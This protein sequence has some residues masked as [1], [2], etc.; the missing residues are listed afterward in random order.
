MKPIYF[1]NY[2][3]SILNVT[4]SI[5][6][7]YGAK[8]WH[9]TLNILDEYL[10]NDYR[11]VVLLLIDGLGVDA[12]E[13]HLTKRSTIRKS[14]KASISSVFPSTTVA[15]TTS[16]LSGKSPLETGWFGWHQYFKEEDDNV[17]LFKNKSFYSPNKVYDHNVANTYI[18]YENIYSQ[19]NHAN[20]SVQ[21]HE[22]FPAFRDPENFTIDKLLKST[23][24]ILKTPGRHFIYAYWDKVDTLMHEFGPSSDEVHK[25][26]SEVNKAYKNFV[27]S[28]DDDTLV[29]AIAD[30]GQV[31]VEIIDLYKY[32]DILDTLVRMPSNESRATIFYVKPDK[33]EEFE[34]LFAN[35]FRHYF[36]LYTAQ[37]VLDMNLFG[38]GNA[39]PKSSEFL[40]DYVAI[41]IDNYIFN[42]IKEGFRMKGQHAGLLVEQMLVPLIITTKKSH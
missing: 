24:S 17:I 34:E 37:R 18:S 30:H 21:T 33:F 27:Q 23:H 5:L 8:N 16:V 9:P 10:E 13:K 36:N 38:L 29:I 6:K 42:S 28:I 4:N 11:N 1:P 15:A 26:I 39:H 7:Y 19:I 3:N 2:K 31:D 14:V 35:N 25:H 32:H 40:G 22:V 12:I 41:A 20:S